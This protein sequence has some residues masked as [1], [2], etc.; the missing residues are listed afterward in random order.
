[1][2]ERILDF[3]ISNEKLIVITNVSGE[4]NLYYFSPDLSIDFK[5]PLDNFDINNIQDLSV[6]GN[7]LIIRH[8]SKSVKIKLSEN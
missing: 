4:N 7:L 6:S 8:D 3:E 5:E 1:M 2:G